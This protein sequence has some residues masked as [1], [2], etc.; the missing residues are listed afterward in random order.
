MPRTK[1]TCRC[2]GICMTVTGAPIM[3]VECH[4]TSCQSAAAGFAAAVPAAHVT[5]KNGGTQYVMVRKDRL[6]FDLGQGHLAAQ[7]L[8]PQSATRRVLA[9]CCGTPLFLEF[10]KGHWLSVYA[11]LWPDDSRPPMA[12]R[13]MTR[14][15]VGDQPLADDMPNPKTHTVGFMAKLLAA[16]FAMGLRIPALPEIPEKEQAHV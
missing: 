12:M 14:D 16:W 4:C 9:S 3:A 15:H 13:T 1:L 2:G 8:T 6:T 5:E 11:G 10:T 7:R